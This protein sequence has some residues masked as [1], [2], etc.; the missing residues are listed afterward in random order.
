MRRYAQLG[1]LEGAS[2]FS[3]L[4]NAV[5]SIAIP[6]LVLE[7]SGNAAA[8]GVVAA[9]TTVPMLLATA[10]GGA[11]VDRIGR[12]RASVGSDLVSA[13]AV[14]AIPLVDGSIGLG[15]TGLVLLAIAGSVFDPAAYT[16]REAMLP[17][18][19]A[20]ARLTL[21]RVNG[22]HE[23]VQGVGF[24]IGPGLGG[25]LI[26]L[27]GAAGA[28]WLTVGAFLTSAVLVAA[29]RLSGNERPESHEEAFWA[30]VATG[31]RFVWREPLLR[32]VGLLVAALTLVI[33]P[34]GAVVFPVY[35]QRFGEA[36]QLGIVLAA[37]SIGGIVGAIGYGVVGQR[38]PR[39]R[40]FLLGLLGAA[41][42]VAVIAIA[43]ETQS[44]YLVMVPAA[45]FT[46]LVSGP[47][48]PLLN[49]A[50]QER[51]PEA[52]RGRVLGTITTFALAA[53]PFGYLV[54]GAAVQALGVGTA[55]IAVAALF[56][57]VALAA[58]AVPAL[59][60]FDDPPVPGALPE[61]VAPAAD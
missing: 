25:L 58:F 39:R 7:T 49:L 17:A 16:A 20:S 1:M 8:A 15:V 61:G 19:A 60:R 47:V 11:I 40:T 46:G 52:L 53:G 10:V 5:A 51:T 18:A 4:G 14:A 57:V 2:A 22:I 41:L 50:I 26:A 43:M 3:V 45:I 44:S 33:A 36:W 35:F 31:A 12:R 13:G 24:L 34:L 9:V 55:A 6:W 37:F 27:V 28:L 59:H 29:L 21:E 48:N 42:G 54:A 56:V 23:A 32:A 38:L 30:S